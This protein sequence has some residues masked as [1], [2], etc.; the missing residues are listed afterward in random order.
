MKR[1]LAFMI[2]VMLLCGCALADDDSTLVVN[3]SGKVF[4]E[5]NQASASLGISMTGE[6]LAQL[7]QQANE[8]VAG[9]YAALVQAGLDEKNIS[10]NYFF[11]S[12]RYDYSD[13]TEKIVGY[14][15][16]NS[17]TIV[18]DE[19]DKIGAYIDAAFA[20]GANTFDSINFTVKDDSDAR[21]Q[22]LE[23]AV[24]DA[25]AKAD[26]IAAASGMGL[27]SVVEI[28]EIS[29]NEYYYNSATGSAKFAAAESA[30]YDAGTTVRAAQVKV[31]ANVEISY[32]LK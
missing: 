15:I 13:G 6:D 32:E 24:Q 1:L 22:A 11:M 2:V 30:A 23:L 19:I 10:T 14:S 29:Q 26:V 17:L 28:K 25:R 4:M 7:Q 9:I 8:T 31:T 18:T 21:K 27:E 12:P 5:A 3:G 16:N 20:A